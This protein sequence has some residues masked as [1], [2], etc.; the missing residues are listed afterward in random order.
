MKIEDY[1]S[2]LP[3]SIISGEDVELSDNTLREIFRFAELTVNDVFYHLGC[4]SS[5]S[6]ATVSY[7][8]LTLPTKR[9]V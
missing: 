1:I 7:T 5:N 3:N 2:S 4:G 8:H 6:I 9:I